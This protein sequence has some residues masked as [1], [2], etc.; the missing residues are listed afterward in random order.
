MHFFY[1][2]SGED[3]PIRIIATGEP[4]P[5]KRM[6]HMDYVTY[7]PKD[8]RKVCNNAEQATLR[9]GPTK[10]LFFKAIGE[11]GRVYCLHYGAVAR[12]RFASSKGLDRSSHA[13]GNGLSL[14]VQQNDSQK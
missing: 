10:G 11:L 1:H 12:K 9:F 3:N 7:E 2:D 4:F 6:Q 14:S 5:W 8:H 13:E